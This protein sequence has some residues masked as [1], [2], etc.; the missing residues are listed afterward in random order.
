MVD[1]QSLA[2]KQHQAVELAALQIRRGVAH[3]VV[4]VAVEVARRQRVVRTPDNVAAQ[5]LPPQSKGPATQGVKGHW[6]AGRRAQP[7]EVAA[8]ALRA[9]TQTL[10]GLKVVVTAETVLKTTLLVWTSFTVAV[11]VAVLMALHQL[12]ARQRYLL[13]IPGQA[14][15]GEV[16]TRPRRDVSPSQMDKVVRQTKT[17]SDSTVTLA[18]RIPA[19]AEAV[20][21]TGRSVGTVDPELS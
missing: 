16:E 19:V 12:I 6:G 5:V 10:T 4:L 13:E 21:L 2:L 20:P 18:W 1:S 8:P 14:V 3:R 9:K 7:E 11:A 17:E 15:L